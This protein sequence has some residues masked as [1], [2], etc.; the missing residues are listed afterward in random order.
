VPGPTQTHGRTRRQAVQ[1]RRDQVLRAAAAVFSEKGYHHAT[2][3]DIAAAAGVSEGTIYNYFRG[4]SDLLVGMIA[5][6]AELEALDRQ[7]AQALQET[8]ARASL[9]I[10]IRRRIDLMERN[11]QL[12]RAILPEIITS[13]ELRRRFLNQFLAKTTQPLEGYLRGRVQT[14][15]MRPMDVPLCVRAIQ[16][17]FLGLLLMRL[18]GEPEVGERWQDLPEVLASLI[19]DGLAPRSSAI[20]ELSELQPFLDEAGN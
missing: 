16:S 15:Q 14:G 6:L 7:L 8:D 18:M 20:A 12:V 3:K 9:V 13:P 10:L 17:A 4:K 2:T 1:A 19:Y 5:R 11:E